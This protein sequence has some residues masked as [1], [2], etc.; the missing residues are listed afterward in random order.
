MQQVGNK[1]ACKETKPILPNGEVKPQVVTEGIKKPQTQTRYC[2]QVKN[3]C[4]R[5]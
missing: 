1:D 3:P 2:S 5:T 4:E